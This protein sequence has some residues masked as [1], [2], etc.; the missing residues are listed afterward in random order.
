MPPMRAGD[1]ITFLALCALIMFP[2]WTPF[3]AALVVDPAPVLVPLTFMYTHL[4]VR[5]RLAVTIFEKCC[6]RPRDSIGT[7]PVVAALWI[8]HRAVL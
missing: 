6:L 4:C 5:N 3:P 1:D 7:R 2:P 8:S